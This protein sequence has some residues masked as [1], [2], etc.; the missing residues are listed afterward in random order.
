MNPKL[1]ILLSAVAGLGGSGALPTY[2]RPKTYENKKI[3][4]DRVT[5]SG[6]I[7]QS[8]STFVQ[9]GAGNACAGVNQTITST[10]TTLVTIT[11]TGTVT[12]ESWGPGNL[13]GGNF[14]SS[15]LSVTNGQVWVSYNPPGTINHPSFWCPQAQTNCSVAVINSTPNGACPSV[16]S[17]PAGLTGANFVCAGSGN[18][19]TSA[20]PGAAAIGTTRFKGGAQVGY[21]G[22][23]GAGPDG[24]GLD[25][26]GSTGG[27]GD[28]GSG[29][30]GGIGCNPG[31]SNVKGGGGAGACGSAENGG[32]PGGGAGGGGGTNGRGQGLVHGWLC[33]PPN[34]GGRIRV[35][36]SGYG[37]G[38]IS[39]A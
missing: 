36:G 38:T 4:L 8:V 17:Y 1:G 12:F 13:N 11:C 28:N 7:A 3:D 22:G 20:S 16:G 14:S 9:G 25:G 29:G 26:S 21:P 10:G 39:A 31:V 33:A 35:A 30:A 2:Y 34:D 37:G 27:A 18:Q 15:A 5:N 23:G 32:A 19:H 24:V 6:K